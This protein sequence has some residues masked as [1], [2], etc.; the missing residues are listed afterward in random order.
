MPPTQAIQIERMVKRVDNAIHNPSTDYKSVS[1]AL[2]DL[3]AASIRPYREDYDHWIRLAIDAK[4]EKNYV[5]YLGTL[6]RQH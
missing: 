5:V 1:A 3:R 2:A 6:K 4:D